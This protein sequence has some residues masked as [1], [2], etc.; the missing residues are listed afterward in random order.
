MAMQ[1]SGLITLLILIPT[2]ILADAHIQHLNLEP[3]FE[4]YNGCFVFYDE[5]SKSYLIYNQEKCERRVSPCSTFKIY[6]ALIGLE[7][8]I[9]ADEHT[10]Y[11]WD[12]EKY[13]IQEWNQDHN[14]RSAIEYSVV[15]YFQQV[16]K[17]VGF[18][19]E[20][21]YLEILEYGNQEIVEVDPP[22]WLQSTLKISP[23]EQV[24]LLQKF[25]YEDLPFSSVNIQMVK[26]AILLSEE[27][28]AKI[29]GK[30]GSGTI[31]GKAVN[32]WFIGFIENTENVIY[33]ATN[34]ESSDKAYGYIA[35][36]IT[37]KILTNLGYIN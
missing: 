8:G 15:W 3:Y 32:G 12:G 26:K 25:Y 34:I 24:K 28:G 22:F 18:I 2:I 14:L 5:S 19:K 21:Y 27:K 23:I 13:P 37:L 6:H 10:T 36:E 17:K 29:F 7:T 35:K 4:N 16:A 9:L 30:T 31:D 1:K 11:E 20:K 33:F